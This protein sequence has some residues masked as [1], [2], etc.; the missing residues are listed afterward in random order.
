MDWLNSEYPIFVPPHRASTVLALDSG[1]KFSCR[2]DEN[3]SVA[4]MKAAEQ[5]LEVKEKVII[6]ICSHIHATSYSALVCGTLD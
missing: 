5:A 1:K 3:D 6:F 4:K 2:G